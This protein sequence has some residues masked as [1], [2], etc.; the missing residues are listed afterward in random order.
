MSPA[1]FG[2]IGALEAFPRRLAAREV[3]R[4]GGHLRRGVSRQ[5]SHVVFG[6]TLLAKRPDAEIAARVAA[7]RAAGRRLLS[8][9]GF[10]RHL[11]LLP[12][13][14]PHGLT[15]A[16]LAQ[17]GLAP[18]IVDLLALFDMFERDAA[19]FAFRDLVLARSIA[20]LIAGGAQWGAIARAHHRSGAALRATS[21]QLGGKA[22]YARHGDRL[23]EL[24]GQFLLDFAAADHDADELFAAAE[25][26][27]QAGRP[28][29]AARLYRRCLARDPGDA[30]AAFN[31]ANCL[32]AAG[33]PIEAER[34]YLRALQL[35]PSFTEAWFN[36]AGLCKDGGRPDKARQHLEQAIARDPDY[37]DAIYNL[38]S[39]AFDTGDL[40]AAGRLWRRYL[41]LDPSSDWARTAARGLQYL[42]QQ[43]RPTG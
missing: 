2:I 36:L 13:P 18:A 14:D 41:E 24:D 16:E 6:R 35:D 43:S 11:G 17:S 4:S 28:V 9:A 32:R 34:E 38:A 8:E 31:R 39:L 30:A 20:G 19:P 15:R 26:A 3:E 40:A 5:T 1:T 10:L 23:S 42:A 37:A 33:E 25:I 22:I 29:E 21:L 12:A 7:E 27:E